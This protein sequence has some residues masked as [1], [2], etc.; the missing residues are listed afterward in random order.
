MDIDEFLS[1]FDGLAQQYYD[2][3]ITKDDLKLAVLTDMTAYTNK[4]FVYTGDIVTV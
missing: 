4:N 3:Y 2:G 1:R